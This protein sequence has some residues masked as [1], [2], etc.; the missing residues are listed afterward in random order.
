MFYEPMHLY[1]LKN[2][3]L[4]AIVRVGTLSLIDDFPSAHRCFPI[5][6]RVGTLTT[7]DFYPFYIYTY[8]FSNR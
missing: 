1:A 8:S 6:A 3:Y 2:E 4:P 5:R 7:A